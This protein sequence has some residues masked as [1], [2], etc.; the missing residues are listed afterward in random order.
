MHCWETKRALET[1][2]Y[3]NLNILTHKNIYNGGPNGIKREKDNKLRALLKEKRETESR[4]SSGWYTED[5]WK[6]TIP[7]RQHGEQKPD[8]IIH[9]TQTEHEVQ[10]QHRE[11]SWALQRPQPGQPRMLSK[12]ERW[13]NCK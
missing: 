3:L 1:W 8:Q 6:D 13:K 2:K 5:E 7:K 9:K 11:E 10:Q 4:V 12:E